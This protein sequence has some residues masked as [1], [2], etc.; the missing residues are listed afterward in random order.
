MKKK[1]PNPGSQEAIDSGCGCPV[2]DNCRGKGCY[3]DGKT[4]IIV[5][6]CPLH[7]NKKYLRSLE[8]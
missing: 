6:G 5:V 3:C 7:D 8:K 2:L 4:F 1:L